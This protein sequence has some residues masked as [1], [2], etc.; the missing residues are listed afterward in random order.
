MSGDDRLQS[1]HELCVFMPIFLLTYGYGS[2]APP[3]SL[4][5]EP[6]WESTVEELSL[7]SSSTWNLIFLIF[8]NSNVK[9]IFLITS[10]LKRKASKTSACWSFF[11]IR[12]HEYLLHLN[13]YRCLQKGVHFAKKKQIDHVFLVR[14]LC[15]RAEFS[16]SISHHSQCLFDLNS[17][18]LFVLNRALLK[19]F[20]SCSC[21]SHRYKY[22]DLSFSFQSG[23]FWSHSDFSIVIFF[24]IFIVVMTLSLS[25]DLR[26]V[27]AVHFER[28][29]TVKFIQKITEINRR[30]LFKM[31]KNWTYC[32]DVAFFSLTICHRFKV[33]SQYHEQK[34][35]VYVNQRSIV[36]LNE[37]R[38]FV[39]NEFNI[40]IDDSIINRIFRG[41]RWML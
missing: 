30:Q 38:W 29:N 2:F 1:R 12:E 27:I 28:K 40:E 10:F 9:H 22:I 31:K 11:R 19:C 24:L 18:C 13:T 5:T 35:L 39:L 15:S 14:W 37:I 21:S 20:F 34:L 6:R 23:E 33:L 8:I 7:N 3:S 25:N 36:Y 32:D 26:T 17:W 16:N 41:L 4:W